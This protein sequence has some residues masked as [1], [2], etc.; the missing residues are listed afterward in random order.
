MTDFTAH[1]ISFLPITSFSESYLSKSLKIILA[2]CCNSTNVASLGAG[3]LPS[4]QSSGSSSRTAAITSDD[5]LNFPFLMSVA[6][7]NFWAKKE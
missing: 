4:L 6:L 2:N 5:Q 1:N 3:L 7:R